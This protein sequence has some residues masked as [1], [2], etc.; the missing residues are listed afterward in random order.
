MRERA[1]HAQ[2]ARLGVDRDLDVPV[3][4]ALLLGREKI[5]VPVLDPFDRA[6]HGERRG[7]KRA[8]FGI[9]AAL[10]P[11]AAADV[12]RDDA[13]LMI[14]PFHQIEQH[15]LVPVR[16]LRGHVDRQRIAGRVR[17]RDHAAAFHEERP[18]AM[19]EDLLAEHMRGLREGR[20]GIA[21]IDRDEG[22]EIVR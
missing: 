4:V 9:E 6:A 15:A 16:P 22:G 12:R 11:E 2:D 19:L 17:H 10:W 21:D 3:L 7:G 20:I 13:Q 1:A 18:A 14:R 8:I 5:L